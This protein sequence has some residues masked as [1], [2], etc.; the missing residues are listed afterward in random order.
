MEK[1]KDII[2][3][4]TIDEVNTI[5][6]ALGERPFNEVF[7]LIGKINAQANEQLK[8]EPEDFQPPNNN[9]QE[10]LATFDNQ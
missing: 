6:K 5:F 8:E 3:A 7:E 9:S 4:L 10:S 2:L 1:E